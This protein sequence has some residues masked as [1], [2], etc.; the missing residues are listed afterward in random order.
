M[1]CAILILEYLDFGDLL[2]AVQV[3]RNFKVA[4]EYVFKSKYSKRVIEIE[5]TFKCPQKHNPINIGDLKIKTQQFSDALETTSDKE[6]EVKYREHDHRIEIL[7]YN[8]IVDTFKQFAIS[9]LA[10]ILSKHNDRV[11]AQLLGQ[12]I[13]NYSSE[14]LKSIIFH[15]TH[16]NPLEIIAKPLVN[17]NN[18]TFYENFHSNISVIL[19][20]DQLF[21]KIEA[22]FMFYETTNVSYFNCH[23]PNLKYLYFQGERY[24]PA[25][26]VSFV[27]II[28]KNPQI[29]SIK[30][31]YIKPEYILAASKLPNLK[32]F[33]VADF[34]ERTIQTRFQTVR[35]FTARWS[36]KAPQ[37]FNFPN[38]RIFRLELVARAHLSLWTNFLRKHSY[39]TALHLEQSRIDVEGTTPENPIDGD[40]SQI[41]A[42]LP[43]LLEMS[44]TCR[45]WNDFE[46]DY[47]VDMIVAALNTHRNL[48]KFELIFDEVLDWETLRSSFDGINGEW[49]ITDIGIGVSFVRL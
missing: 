18:V 24:P 27:H 11:P 39:I 48:N 20:V 17:V 26:G 41:M 37:S 12:L 36:P 47:G 13:S 10:I 30:A 46:N 2:S 9:N 3:N 29:E 19:P 38:L 32:N 7:D 8:M 31:D 4:A 6:N 33:T 45:S 14:S 42:V 35:K 44:V 34:K 43:N 40:F 15:A 28:Q 1:D 23:M 25:D 21:P 22:L 16:F 5:D 49:L